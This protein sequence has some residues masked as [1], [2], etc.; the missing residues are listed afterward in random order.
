MS[1][2]NSPDALQ[3]LSSN[4][5]VLRKALGADVTSMVATKEQLTTLHFQSRYTQPSSTKNES[6]PEV[7]Q[8]QVLT[9]DGGRDVGVSRGQMSQIESELSEPRLEEEHV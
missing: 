9:A 5:I 6:T 4:F 7:F 8:S 3:T 1:V 2:D